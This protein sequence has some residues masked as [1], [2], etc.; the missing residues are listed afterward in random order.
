MKNCIINLILL[1]LL[2]CSEKH[3]DTVPEFNFWSQDRTN[4]VF[5]QGDMINVGS[6]IYYS[7]KPDIKGAEGSF[8]VEITE[9]NS[10][11]CMISK[12]FTLAFPRK[13]GLERGFVI[14]AD[15]IFK[16]FGST[17]KA[18]CG[19]FIL[20]LKNTDNRRASPLWSCYSPAKG[21][22]KISY[23]PRGISF[24]SLVIDSDLGPR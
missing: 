24:N 20:M 18:E 16:V 12:D 15:R 22:T 13:L 7:G 23:D 5:I 10:V 17:Q 9:N 11:K 21:I 6:V 4:G 14:C 2:G 3:S 8:T 19:G 1:A